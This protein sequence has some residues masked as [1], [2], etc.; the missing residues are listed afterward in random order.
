MKTLWALHGFLGL[1][2]D[3]DFLKA[4]CADHNVQL[5]AVNLYEAVGKS[6]NFEE[7]TES[8]CQTVRNHGGSNQILGYSLGGRL[9]LHALLKAP[10]LFE[11]AVIVSS[12]PGLCSADE[13][14]DRIKAD[15]V[16]A[17]SFRS[18]SWLPLMENWNRQ[19]VFS[20]DLSRQLERPEQN[21]DRE[22]LAQCFEKW[23]LGRQENLRT[24]LLHIDRPL[25]WLIGREDKKFT[26]LAWEVD[27]LSDKIT[28]KT[29]AGAGHRLPWDRQ[30]NFKNEIFNFL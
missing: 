27:S 30:E 4:P 5:K 12:H 25:L 2:T 20:S 17:E 8:F 11:S 22:L 28:V 23:S 29:V 16:W 13:R 14:S 3:W 21:Y 15:Q 18:D 7:W 24:Q 26:D 19:A 1:T 10:E 6:K 9:G